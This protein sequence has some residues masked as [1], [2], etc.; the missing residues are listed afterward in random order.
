MYNFG[1]ELR[2]WQ[3]QYVAHTSIC[4]LGLSYYTHGR[5]RCKVSIDTNTNELPVVFEPLLLASKASFHYYYCSSTSRED[6]KLEIYQFYI[7]WDW[8]LS[9]Q[10]SGHKCLSSFFCHTTMSTLFFLKLLSTPP[11]P[12]KRRMGLLTWREC[13]LTANMIGW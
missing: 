2:R 4:I 6:T 7:S 11:L 3:R 10:F 9:W 12:S 13:L 1:W 5:I 8:S